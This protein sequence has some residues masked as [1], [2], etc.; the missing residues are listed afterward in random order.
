MCCELVIFF[1]V[2]LSIKC[3]KCDSAQ[4]DCNTG[5]C[6]GVWCVASVTENKATRSRTIHKDCAS[7][8]PSGGK[9]DGC[10][11][12]TQPDGADNYRC[13]CNSGDNCNSEAGIARM[14]AMLNNQFSV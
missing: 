7:A 12:D 2:S 1:S 6:D 3:Q 10:A 14:Q 11:K 5:T 4:G 8:S 13:G 9:E